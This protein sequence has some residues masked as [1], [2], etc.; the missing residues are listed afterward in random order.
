MINHKEKF[1]F[2]HIPKTGGTSV[3]S[4][5]TKKESTEKKRHYN[6]IK[7]GLN[8]NE[9]DKYRIFAVLRNPFTRIASTYNHFMHG[10]DN[11][12]TS[13]TGGFVM[14]EGKVYPNVKKTWNN[15]NYTFHQYVL[16]I[17]KYF[18]GEYEVDKGNRVYD[19]EGRRILD[20]HHI[21][22]MSWWVKTKDNLKSKCETLRFESLNEDWENFKQKINFTETLKKVKKDNW[23][24]PDDVEYYMSFYDKESKKIIQELYVEELRNYE[25]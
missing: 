17:R 4:I 22:T 20:A 6:L 16:N 9:C 25:K 11:K 24:L 1:I 5:L 14:L 15:S 3:E 8:K 18:N 13:T 23:G 21:E 10:P 2:L 19:S 7:M 12:L